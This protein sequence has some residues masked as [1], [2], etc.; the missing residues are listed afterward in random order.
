MNDHFYGARSQ[1]RKRK[2]ADKILNISIGVV[3]FLILL[4]G[5]QLLIG[6]KSADPVVSDKLVDPETKGENTETELDTEDLSTDDSE[7]AEETEETDHGSGTSEQPSSGEEP[8]T[9]T[10]E[11]ATTLSTGQWAPIGT[12]QQEPFAAVYE[13]D[14]VNWEEMIRAFQVAT[15]LGDNMIL[16]R[17]KNGGD[18]QS[19]FGYVS[20][21]ENSNTPFRVRIEWVT[22]EGWMPVS[23]ELLNENPYK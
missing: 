17:V 15:G 20:D 1:K 16:W 19:A 14:H 5:G 7:E 2:R 8:E 6:G 12:V 4:I 21:S 10:E 18:H 11:E 13:K 23:V 9:T 3:I 22:N